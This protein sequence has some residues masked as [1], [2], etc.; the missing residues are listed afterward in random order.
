MEAPHNFLQDENAATPPQL[1]AEKKAKN[2]RLFKIGLIWLAVGV[3]LMGI[4]FVINFLFFHSDKSFGTAMYVLTTAG[5][6][7]IFKGLANILG[8]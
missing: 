4:S 6:A 8:F 2:D 7:C 1:D 3:F 5:F